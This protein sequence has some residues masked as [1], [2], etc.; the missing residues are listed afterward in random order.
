MFCWKKFSHS[1]FCGQNFSHLK[2]CWKNLPLDS[3]E[4]QF[5]DWNSG[6]RFTPFW[7]KQLKYTALKLKVMEGCHLQKHSW[8]CQDWTNPILSKIQYWTKSGIKSNL[9]LIKITYNWYQLMLMLIYRYWF[10][11]RCNKTMLV[12][13]TIIL[14]IKFGIEYEY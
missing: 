14:G 4:N 3:G 7:Q 10:W 13:W 8:H 2:F 1:K 11:L 9:V 12:P 6:L 5:T